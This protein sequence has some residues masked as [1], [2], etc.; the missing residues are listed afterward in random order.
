MS[1]SLPGARTACSGASG[2]ATAEAG[3]R[4]EVGVRFGPKLRQPQEPAHRGAALSA[5]PAVE[6]WSLRQQHTDPLHLQETHGSGP[7][8]AHTGAISPNRTAA[9]QAASVHRN[10]GAGGPGPNTINVP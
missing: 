9:S 6:E 7:G 8:S 10:M 4:T 2:A 5:E 3:G 1:Q